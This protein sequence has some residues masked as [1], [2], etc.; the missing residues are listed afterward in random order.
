MEPSYEAWSIRIDWIQ[1]LQG[2]AAILPDP[3][4]TQRLAAVVLGIALTLLALWMLRSFVAALAW[5][6]VIA[7][8]TWPL[9]RRFMKGW[10]GRP[11]NERR[12][13]LPALLFT[14]L[15]GLILVLPLGF[16]AFE[17]GN[18]S[19][20]LLHRAAQTAATGLPAPG[21]L[22][23][24]PVVGER[25]G[26]WWTANLAEPGKA[27]DFLRHLNDSL[28]L[29][30]ARDVG[31]AVVHR[32]ILF[33][34]TLLALFFLFRDGE[35]LGAE[36][37]GLAEHLLG[38]RGRR[39]GAQLIVAVRA[40]VNGLV[41]VGLGE[42]LAWGLACLFAGVPHPAMV[43]AL[44]GLLAIIPFGMPIAIFAVAGVML[45]EGQLTLAIVLTVY[46]LL[47]VFVADH[48]IRP[49]LISGAARLPFL[50]VL[51]GLLGGLETFGL[52]GL[53]LGPAVLAALM[54]LWRDWVRPAEA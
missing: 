35:K 34:F 47:V 2:G 3:R 29:N 50:W 31:A 53:F 40:T 25:L 26:E 48:L 45:S 9:Y 36:I 43:G 20:Q 38:E 27:R 8:A 24:V 1:Q 28:L 5:A 13:A 33:L 42:G 46:G 6:L 12:R 32:V 11:E 54:A 37:A 14:L 49:A 44:S 22:D 7:I 30:W 51:L 4:S 17:L 16:G 52:L 15:L 23:R 21:W 10:H 41:L 19:F 39:L 18:E